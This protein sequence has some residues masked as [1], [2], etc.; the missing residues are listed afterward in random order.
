[1]IGIMKKISAVIFVLLP[2]FAFQL[3]AQGIDS[4]KFR[5][6]PAN[7]MREDFNYLR[8]LLEET[9]PGLYRYS[10]KEQIK[11][12]LDSLDMRLHQP[13]PFYSFYRELCSLMAD[14]RCAHTSALPRQN[15]ETYLR[16]IRMLPFF[17]FP[18]QG[19]SYVVF[20]GTQDQTIKPG[21]ELLSINGHRMDSVSK[22]LKQNFWA[23][24]YIESSK[25]QVMQGSTFSLFYYTLIEMPEN[26][27]LRFKDMNGKEISASVQ[28]QTLSVSEKQYARNPVNAVTAKLYIKKNKSPWRLSFLEDPLSTAVIRLDGFGGK[29]MND[30]DEAREGMRKFM[31]ESLKKI[32]QN[33]SKHLIIDVRSNTGGWDTQGVELLTYLIQSDSAFQY[34]R[35]LYAISDSS[36]FLKFSDL[37]PEDLKNVK[38]ELKKEADGT[39]TMRE[40]ANPDLKLQYPKP[41]RFRGKIYVL[42]NGRSASTASEFL[43][44]AKSNRIGT[45]IGEESGGAY[46]G[47]DGGWGGGCFCPVS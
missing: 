27:Y 42:M 19:K 20:N 47:G 10:T 12:K 23:D 39:F 3:V 46:D 31:D 29:G 26:F 41:N 28:A 16:G 34:Y 36:E 24:G 8:R 37:S 18:I 35:R 7:E 21:F 13:M 32:S 30:G 44:V 40:E 38:K 25:D 15:I 43:A 14:I 9:H 45:F 4:L 33:K 22:L 2:A 5:I 1:M 17:I 11:A 6:L